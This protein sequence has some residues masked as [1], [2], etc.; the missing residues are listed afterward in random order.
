MA[1]EPEQAT[2]VEPDEAELLDQGALTWI[3]TDA[4]VPIVTQV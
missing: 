4:E 3:L 2:V 1:A